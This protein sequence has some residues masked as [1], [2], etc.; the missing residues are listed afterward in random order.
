ME[1]PDDSLLRGLACAAIEPGLRALLL[2]DCGPRAFPGII[3]AAEA[4]L[5]I[6]VSEPVERVTLSAGT[7]E[8]DDLW[9][10]LRL[11][12]SGNGR[13]HLTPRLGRLASAPE[14]QT[15]KLV[16]IP[17]LPGLGLAAQRACIALMDALVGVLARHGF[18]LAWPA[19]YYWIAAC[20]RAR[21]GELPVHLLERFVLRLTPRAPDGS[22]GTDRVTAL[23]RQL[24]EAS[25]LPPSQP[26][27]EWPKRV[28]A[29]AKQNTQ[30][31][32]QAVVAATEWVSGPRRELALAR[33][34]RGLARLEGSGTCEAKHIA[35]AG[36]LLGLQDPRAARAGEQ[37]PGPP[38]KPL[39]IPSE[40][41]SAQAGA[42]GASS[43]PAISRPDASSSPGAGESP[44]KPVEPDT[45]SGLAARVA[46]PVA[47]A[48]DP[49]PEDKAT[50]A[51]ELGSLRLPARDS[52][53]TGAPRGEVAGTQRALSTTDI[54]WVSTLLE[55]AR[56][57]VLRRGWLR[58]QGSGRGGGL[59][60]TPGDLRSWRRVPP[61]EQALIVVLDLT[62]LAGTQWEAGLVPHL[63]WAYVER[64]PVTLIQVGV[65]G[66]NEEDQLRANRIQGRNLLAPQ[67]RAGFMARPGAA[68]PLAHGLEMAAQAARHQLE[69]GR[70]RARHVRVVVVT[71]GRGNVPLQ[72]S[73]EGRV[74]SPVG[75]RGAEDALVAAG[76]LG[77]LEQA[78]KFLLH[79][80]ADGELEAPGG[81]PGKLSAA[82]RTTPGALKPRQEGAPLR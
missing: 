46:G 36:R 44:E 17:D 67:V 79:P 6:V 21:I 14:S 56:F 25:S 13:P 26:L 74:D 35:A 19:N 48:G 28:S 45:T 38:A 33:L 61:A 8:E 81:W 11:E 65:A 72:A 5:R 75:S 49:F 57:Q 39:F 27:G 16:T 52:G 82:M 18:H 7:S 47:A 12:A 71:D 63:Q 24:R 70:N 3:D 41:P 80:L 77:E 64:A 1:S 9:M 32:D 53:I 50:P 4:L 42:S 23:G 29:G 40:R 73:L 60:L 69:H 34:A 30:V 15:L 20:P 22:T 31:Q 37:Q 55:A 78:E 43:T 10:D 76:H 2:L 58:K 62:C 54:A 68:T 66:P 51:R 59:I